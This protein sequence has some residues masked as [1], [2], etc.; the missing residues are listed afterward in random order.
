M[1]LENK[2]FEI[3]TPQDFEAVALEVFRFQAENCA[4]YRQYIDL[5]GVA[6]EAIN[7]VDDIPFLPISLFRT[8]D[9]YT[10]ATVPE[11]TFTSSG[12]TGEQTS[13]HLVASMEM[14]RRSFVHNFEAFYGD[15][16]QWAIFFL[17]PNYVERQGS[18][19][20]L[21]AE[22]LN[23]MSDPRGGGF[24]LYDHPKL[25][26]ELET[27]AEQ[28]LKIMVLG[29]TFALLDFAEK[30]SV[31]LPHTAVVMETGGMK[32]RRQ[33]IQRQELHRILCQAFAV[34]AIHSE[35][36]MTELLSQAYS[37]GEGV[38]R[39]PAQMRVLPRKLTNPLSK[40][41]YGRPSGLNVI[42]LA[43][44][45]SCSFIATADMGKVNA[46]GSFEIIGR[47]E[48]EILRGCNML[49]T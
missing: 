29:V 22:E 14:Y 12:T 11:V 45:Y 16:R 33:Q 37:S 40:G 24:Y 8:H 38:F 1:D 3:V 13:R 43:N 44:L 46:D 31:A 27:A 39:T 35:Y 47:I 17:L 4:P 18:S 6:P 21:M 48:G 32:G 42:D 41:E 5:L 34:G 23:Q 26:Q 49:T 19:L 15:P 9:I 20:T 36:G 28:G 7:R 10:Q 2:I 25:K 30:F